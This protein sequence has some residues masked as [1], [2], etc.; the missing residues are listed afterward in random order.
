MSV[1]NDMLQ[2]LEQRRYKTAESGAAKVVSGLQPGSYKLAR[3]RLLWWLL[4]VFLVCF[5][6]GGIAWGY[7][8]LRS[9]EAIRNA[10][11]PLPQ[12]PIRAVPLLPSEP[13][14][15][16]EQASLMPQASIDPRWPET[17]AEPEPKPQFLERIE[18]R[19]QG[20]RYD[21]EMEFS[22]PLG[23]PPLHYRKD[24]Q[25]WL[26]LFDTKVARVQLPELSGQTPIREWSAYLEDGSQ[27]I[28]MSLAPSYRVELQQLRPELWRLSLLPGVKVTQPKINAAREPSQCKAS[29]LA[30]SQIKQPSDFAS[31]EPVI[32]PTPVQKKINTFS[33]AEKAFT[34]GQWKRAEKL[35]KEVLAAEPDHLSASLLLSQLYLSMNAA[36]QAE[37]VI[38]S[39]LRHHAAQPDLVS[40]FAR[41]LLAQERLAEAGDYLLKA[42]R[43]DYAPHVGLLATIRQRQDQH[44]Q[45]RDYYLQA[46]QLSPG[47]GAWLAGLGISQEHLG[48]QAGA[49]QAYR[50][51]LASGKLNLTLQG[52]VEG[53]LAQLSQKRN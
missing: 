6:G 5:V 38:Q 48:D 40:Y 9:P 1:I 35:L 49:R 29:N 43:M 50:G 28:R 41:C 31:K 21:L 14:V 16:P 46:L 18:L 33:E 4:G 51:S 52:F 24:D 34:K 10:A 45:A 11:M 3:P 19:Q 22:Q 20:R 44:R 53:R 37:P 36:K 23:I 47:E 26:Q 12:S 2:D 7:A 8:R 39:A 27:M 15:L 32:S 17:A 13:P 30:P 25:V 42:M